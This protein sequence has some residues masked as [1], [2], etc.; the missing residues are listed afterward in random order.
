MGMFSSQLFIGLLKD[1]TGIEEIAAIFL[2][3]LKRTYA[4]FIVYG[5]GKKVNWEMKKEFENSK[6]I[7]KSVNGLADL[8]K[9]DPGKRVLN[10]SF[11]TYDF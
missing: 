9:S 2:R 8:A 11:K 10:D 7:N 5:G 6:R 4:A 1:V 3:G